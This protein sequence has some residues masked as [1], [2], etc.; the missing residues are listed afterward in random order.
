MKLHLYKDGYDEC[1]SSFE[2]FTSLYQRCLNIEEDCKAI[3]EKYLSKKARLCD[4][5]Y[6]KTAARKNGSEHMMERANDNFTVAKQRARAMVAY[7][8]HRIA[9]EVA[10]KKLDET[11][12]CLATSV[13]SLRRALLHSGAYQDKPKLRYLA[14]NNWMLG[15]ALHSSTGSLLNKMRTAVEVDVTDGLGSDELAKTYDAMVK[16][17]L[18]PNTRTEA[19][20]RAD[21]LDDESPAMWN[22][23]FEQGQYLPWE[24][25]A[26]ILSVTGAASGDTHWQDLF[27]AIRHGQELTVQ[28]LNDLQELETA[29][30]SLNEPQYEQRILKFNSIFDRSNDEAQF[31]VKTEQT[32][33]RCKVA[34]L[35]VG[36]A[37]QVDFLQDA[38]IQILA[39][40]LAVLKAHDQ[41]IR[42]YHILS[43][44][45][46]WLNGV[47]TRRQLSEAMH[48]AE[49]AARLRNEE[50]PDPYQGLEDALTG[51]LL[52]R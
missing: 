23:N 31:R 13:D 32:L 35:K 7:Q 11:R 28:A 15:K 10:I 16:C 8:S 51:N 41:N 9:L 36:L 26:L 3:L 47:S 40:M 38:E 21:L 27:K 45:N 37:L 30:K 6:W 18:A 49:A 2:S 39:A 34:N 43:S 44:M 19:D 1:G 12:D 42:K 50:Y 25:D 22:L 46:N 33:R 17:Y 4:K 48:R 20:H 5:Q 14:I 24:N 52:L 29:Q